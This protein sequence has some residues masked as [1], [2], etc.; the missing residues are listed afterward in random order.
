MNC[1][2]SIGVDNVTGITG[3]GTLG[4]PEQSPFDRIICGAGGPEVPQPWIEQLADPGRLILPVGPTD[5]Q[6]LQLVEKRDGTI[7]RT[8]LGDVRFVKLI[9]KRGFPETADRGPGQTT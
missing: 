5:R 9:G 1:L 7:R 3:D 8:S 2:A 4:W 6:E